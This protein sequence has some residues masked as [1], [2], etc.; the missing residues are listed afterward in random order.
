MD[1]AELQPGLTAFIAERSGADS[2]AVENLV[3]LSGGASRETWAFDARLTGRGSD[4]TIEGIF[5]CDPIKGVPSM[6]GRE[7]EYHLIKAAWDAGVVVP[8]PLWDGD[9]RF[10]L[11]FFTMRRVPGEAL[12]ARLIRGEQYAQAREV[13][14]QQL[15]Q[16]LARVHRVA[17]DQHPELSG[18][19]AP[20]VGVPPARHEVDNYEAS[21]RLAMPNPH[22]VFELAFRWLH[23]HMPTA[24]QDALVHGDFRLGNFLFGE[25]GLRGVIDW[26]LAHWGDPMEDLGWL[27]VRSWRFGGKKPVAGVADREQFFAEYEAAGGFPVDRERV[28]FWELFGNLRWGVI[29]ITQAVQYLSGRSKSVELASIG[30]RTAETEWELLTLLEG[31]GA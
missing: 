13:L 28:R 5:R 21:F 24:E 8:E 3:R 12:G 9:D 18:L 31:K 14:P 1:T 6:P 16:S 4:E 27:A 22:P 10:G 23:E 26:E 30:R 29:T 15:A 25:D 19:P 20:A 17:R 2:V 7:L 11:K